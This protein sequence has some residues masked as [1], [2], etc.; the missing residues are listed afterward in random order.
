MGESRPGFSKLFRR[1]GYFRPHIDWDAGVQEE[2]SGHRQAE[3]FAAA[4]IGFCL[5]HDEKFRS[6]FWSC[7]CRYPAD[8]DPVP[9]LTI[10]VEPE[11]WADLRIACEIDGR[12]HVW[13]IELKIGATLAD[14]QNPL[15][16]DF[17]KRRLG[18][19]WYFKEAE[20]GRSADLR[21]VVLGALLNEPAATGKVIGGLPIKQV[22]WNRLAEDRPRTDLMDDLAECLG[23]LGIVDFQMDRFIK[24]GR[25]TWD[26]VSVVG[27]A[28]EILEGICNQL[29]IGGSS[30]YRVNAYVD[31]NGRPCFGVDVQQATALLK[32]GNP[33]YKLAEITGTTRARANTA[34]FGYICPKDQVM[35]REVWFRCEDPA[36][37]ESLRKWMSK[38]FPV[39]PEDTAP[40]WVVVSPKDADTTDDFTW[41]CSVFK[42]ALSLPVTR[43]P[44]STCSPGT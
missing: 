2:D 12:R 28:W 10:E 17:L 4:A 8:S 16:A 41:F 39:R 27:Y 33:R 32:P 22:D 44:G 38:D 6:H 25:I 40:E 34:W 15:R 36:K 31:D 35:I 13:V 20:K 26:Q 19:G 18:Y 21:Y 42:C 14:K 11:N 5:R 3:R 7:V 23:T 29:K 43:S 37:R 9:D 24:H 30:G 1:S